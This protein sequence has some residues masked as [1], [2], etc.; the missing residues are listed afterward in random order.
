MIH[1]HYLIIKIHMV[2]YYIKILNLWMAI[3]KDKMFTIALLVI[4]SRVVCRLMGIELLSG[5]GL[6]VSLLFWDMMDG[7]GLG[8]DMLSRIVS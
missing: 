5:G 2:N 7:L 4:R 1:N 8:L 3:V 6:V